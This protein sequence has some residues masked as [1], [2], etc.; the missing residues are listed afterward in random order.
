MKQHGQVV[1]SR[2]IFR[3]TF[4]DRTE[5]INSNSANFARLRK[6]INHW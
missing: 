2:I 1:E 5:I 4:I 6:R 3:V